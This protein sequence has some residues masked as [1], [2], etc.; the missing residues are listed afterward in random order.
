VHAGSPLADVRELCARNEA[1]F[2]TV[3]DMLTAALP[4]IDGVER[5]VETVVRPDGTEITL[6]IHTPTDGPGPHPGVLHLH[7]GA[8]VTFEAAW[9]NYQ[10]WRDAL[11]ARG[12]VAIGVEFRNAA[13][14]LGPHPYPAGLD[15]CAT[16]LR[17]AHR[18]RRRLGISELIVSGESGGGNLALATALRA[19][20]D[21]RIDEIAG[22]YAQCPLHLRDLR[23]APTRARVADR[24]RRPSPRL[25][26]DG[27]ARRDVRPGR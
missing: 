1:G 5:T 23:L 10:R 6:H 15:D 27:R 7:G 11:A 8:M 22:V 20:R 13:G 24:E 26:H 9:P 25:R 16:A 12:L 4:A 2:A 17:W 21:G 19:R 18:E 3:V 14:R